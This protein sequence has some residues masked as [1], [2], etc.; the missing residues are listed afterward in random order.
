[1]ELLRGD[2]HLAAKAELAAV[3]E[4]GGDVD[5]DS[6]AVRLAH[7]A[8]GVR[9]VLR[10]DGLAVA[11]GVA[12]DV[13]DGVVDA[14]NHADGEDI[15]EKFRVEVPLPRGCAIDDRGGRRV[16]PQLH[17][18][19]PRRTAVVDERLLQHR[20]ELLRDG[21][22]DKADLLGVAD[23]GAAGLGV[24]DDFHGLV[25]VG[26]L[27]DI[28]VADARSRLDA[29]DGRVFD[30]GADQPRPA[31]RDEQVDKPLRAHQL[32]RA[33]VARVLE[34]VEDV[35]VAAR[36]GDALLECGGDG[37]RA[38]D[39]I[40]PAAQDAD[41]A[42]LDGKRR[43][44]GGDVRTA[45][46]DDRD[47]PQRHLLF[48]DRHTVRALHLGEDPPRV[49]GQLRHGAH[50]VRHRV[51]TRGVEPQ[52]VEHHVGD[53]PARGVH[54]EGVAAQDLVRVPLEALRHGL[55]QTALVLG[56]HGV[57]A[58]PGDLRPADDVHCGHGVIPSFSKIWCR[59]ACRPRCHR[60]VRACCRWR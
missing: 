35:R 9:G 55:E 10:D 58:A 8:L 6:G 56:R 27:V 11:G 25:E 51:D 18:D 42:A 36:G 40:A 46:I 49:I 13:R 12:Q 31:A 41:V 26:V 39:G 2:A 38:A 17:G 1:M 5:V 21:A 57:D 3:G 54:V 4:A 30:A 34:D 44:V 29:G 53:F 33:L 16:E 43:R 23:G 7:E 19:K 45:L 52:A 48:I 15:V 37:L 59:R 20:Q 14:V 22:V 50:A 32:V 24:F 28:D 47:K 60:A